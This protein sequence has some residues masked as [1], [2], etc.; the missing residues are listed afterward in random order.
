[1]R[2]ILK[3]KKKIY[4]EI[5]QKLLF[6]FFKLF[7]HVYKKPV[8]NVYRNVEFQ[9]RFPMSN[10]SQKTAKTIQLYLF[11]QTNTYV[12]LFLRKKQKKFAQPQ[13]EI[14]ESL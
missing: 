8:R 5:Y 11:F 12:F 3:I 4:Y 10:L 9:M 6:I 2:I 7:F 14:K 13:T 1:M